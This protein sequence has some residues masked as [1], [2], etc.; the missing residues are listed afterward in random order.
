VTV[1][2]VSGE[3]SSRGFV[4][5]DAVLPWN[6]A[7]RVVGPEETFGGD[8]TQVHRIYPHTLRGGS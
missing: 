1:A 8:G 2:I 3:S 5:P 7:P 6:L 4:E